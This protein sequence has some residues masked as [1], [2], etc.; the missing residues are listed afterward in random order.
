MYS[1]T[2]KDD[3]V[4]MP[5]NV[6]NDIHDIKEKVQNAANH[7]GQEA[8]H[9]LKTATDEITQASDCVTNEIR[10]NPLRSSIVALGVG[11][12]CGM[13]LRR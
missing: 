11:M 3:S 12:L 4:T 2:T 6:T 10:T 9:F 7:A 8:R 13:L 1:P 5:K